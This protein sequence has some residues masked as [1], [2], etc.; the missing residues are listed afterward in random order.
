MNLEFYSGFTYVKEHKDVTD[1]I[2]NLYA[3][4]SCEFL[5]AKCLNA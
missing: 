1:V 4:G 5:L 2:Y 3:N